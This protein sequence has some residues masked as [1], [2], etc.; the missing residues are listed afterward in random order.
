VLER[1]PELYLNFAHFGGDREFLDM[2]NPGSWANV[3]RGLL[4]R[5]ENTYADLSYHFGALMKSSGCY[6]EVLCG[7]LDDDRFKDR[8]LFGTDWLISRHTWTVK[9]YLDAF[10]NLSSDMLDRIC[11]HNPLNFLFPG[12]RLPHRIRNFFDARGCEESVMPE[13]VRENLDL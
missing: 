4:E 2:D 3:I 9:E 11:F 7:L 12:R 1:Y 10:R 13:F 5:Y 6:F 8:L